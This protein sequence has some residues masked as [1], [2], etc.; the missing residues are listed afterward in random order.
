MSEDVFYEDLGYFI[1]LTRDTENVTCSVQ[2]VDIANT[3]L[4]SFLEAVGWK[5]GIDS[6]YNRDP[7]D[8]I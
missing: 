3:E 2:R 7:L 5:Y 8:D 1:G 6:A 4:H